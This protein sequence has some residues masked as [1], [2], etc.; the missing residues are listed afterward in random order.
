MTRN[1]FCQKVGNYFMSIVFLGNCNIAKI[2]QQ[3]QA[4]LN[5]TQNSKNL[6]FAFSQKIKIDENK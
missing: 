6:A 5:D 2:N 1:F 3:R 4:F